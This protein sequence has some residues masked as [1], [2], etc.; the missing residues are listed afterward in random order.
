[1]PQRCQKIFR[2]QETS[3]K[4]W[5]SVIFYQKSRIYCSQRGLRRISLCCKNMSQQAP[6]PPRTGDYQLFS[7][8]RPFSFLK[9]YLWVPQRCQKISKWQETS[10]K[11]W[12]SVIFYQKSRIYCSQ[13]GLPGISFCCKSMIQQAPKPPRTGNYQHFFLPKTFLIPQKP[14]MG[15]TK[16]SKDF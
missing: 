10:K 7:C 13:R 16:V 11:L 8:P 15:T 6:R 4:L 14:F 9:K 1:M 2:W 5:K 12:K 3:K